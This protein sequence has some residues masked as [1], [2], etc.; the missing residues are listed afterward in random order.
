[1]NQLDNKLWD[2]VH[3]KNIELAE[4]LISQGADV[5]NKDSKG[6]S[7]F[8]VY[9]L[10][11]SYQKVNEWLISKGV[12]VN[13]K[14]SY[15]DSA[16]HEIIKF[17]D[18]KSFEWIINLPNIDINITNDQGATPLMAAASAGKDHFIDDLLNKG[19]DPNIITKWTGS[20]LF[21]AAGRGKLNMV[22]SLLAAGA[23][24]S[25]IDKDGK[26]IMHELVPVSK[27]EE[28]EKN[29][30][31]IFDYLV[32][33]YSDKIDF[34]KR[35]R[36]GTSALGNTI[37]NLENMETMILKGANPNVVFDNMGS[38]TPLHIACAK[39]EVSLINL[40][41]SKGCDFTLQNSDKKT[42]V[43]MLLDNYLSTTSNLDSS[44]KEFLKTIQNYAVQE[45]LSQDELDEIIKDKKQNLKNEK[46]S[47]KEKLLETLQLFIKNGFDPKA[48][49]DD[50]KGF[51]ALHLATVLNDVS[52]AESFVK[53]GFPIETPVV[54][55]KKLSEYNHKVD[56]D[57][58]VFKK[59][60]AEISP[61]PLL[62][63][64]N[65]M[66]LDMVNFLLENS[67]NVNAVDFFG[68]NALN[69]LSNT[70]KDK[71][72]ANA[73]VI[74]KKTQGDSAKLS[75]ERMQL[76]ED[77]IFD[78]IKIIDKLV[79]AGINLNHENEIG[80]TALMKLSK[81]NDINLVGLLI[82][83]ANIDI[84]YKNENEDTALSIA[85]TSGNS[86]LFREMVEEVKKQGRFEETADV[87]TQA[88][89]TSPEEFQEKTRFLK[90]LSSVGNDPL[91]INN[92]E[93][94]I[95]LLAAIE[96]DSSEIVKIL[97]ES[98]ADVNIQDESGNTPL[99]YAAINKDKQSVL[100]LKAAGADV[101]IKND[102]GISPM[103]LSRMSE[104]MEVRNA[105]NAED[106]NMFDATSNFNLDPTLSQENIWEKI[107][108]RNKKNKL[109]M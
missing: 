42:P 70:Q 92:T 87:V 2:A 21:T 82:R 30:L 20:P 14:D 80:A 90:S 16:L 44:F 4:Q 101:N 25:H 55:H 63:A 28:F 66:N 104:Y 15:G 77:L 100:L 99:I 73:E 17:G 18:V 53:L 11:S 72:I 102:K 45:D 5:N 108:E 79:D 107:P 6:K 83:R 65:Q 36:F 12:D 33:N 78:K 75:A 81:N 3:S 43:Y 52:L 34:D 86:L 22:K 41:V 61:P 76:E 40:I 50:S 103:S 47:L 89:L 109:S 1:M 69:Y 37:N 13:S 23:D 84:I 59:E 67:A 32:E 54:K 56:S 88:I 49:M 58:A 35:T 68:D 106:P 51:H 93:G 105:M 8:R 24:P 31:A 71:L 94:A 74:M 46:E 96:N 10:D 19:A 91:W 60:L 29:I 27:G 7:M 9:G 38:I 57:I 95:P 26:S 39:N 64:I 48:I 62:F 98:G 85:L 97:I